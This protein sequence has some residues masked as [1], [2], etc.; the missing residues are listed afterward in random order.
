[1]LAVVLDKG[2]GNRLVVV[3]ECLDGCCNAHDD[4]KSERTGSDSRVLEMGEHGVGQGFGVELMSNARG[5]LIQVELP[6]S[7]RASWLK[8]STVARD[9]G[10]FI[11]G[12]SYPHCR[13]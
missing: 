13:D 12:G 9:W 2:L 6:E 10:D 8:F 1:V 4:E 11:Y 5:A 3:G 7:E